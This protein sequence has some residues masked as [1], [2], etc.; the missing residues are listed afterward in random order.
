MYNSVIRVVIL[1]VMAVTFSS[2]CTSGTTRANT[3]GDQSANKNSG[4][5]QT[6]EG[7]LVRKETAFYIQPHDGDATRVNAGDQDLSS[8]MGQDI[9]LTGNMQ[10]D[11]SQASPSSTGGTGAASPQL[12]VTRVDVV[13]A[14]CPNDIQKKIDDQKKQK[15]K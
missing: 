5:Q 7:C 6:I 15:S 1:L 8:H 13:A 2:G 11:N 10:P 12:V 3:Q 4:Q 9:Q 14:T